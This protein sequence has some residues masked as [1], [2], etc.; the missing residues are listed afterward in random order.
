LHEESKT[1]LTNTEQD[2]RVSH[3]FS[4]G[5]CVMGT[6][7]A[8]AEVPPKDADGAPSIPPQAVGAAVSKLILATNGEI[9]VIYSRSPAHNHHP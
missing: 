8:E 3:L 6:N 7:T 1:I 4:E 5:N 9:A 2:R